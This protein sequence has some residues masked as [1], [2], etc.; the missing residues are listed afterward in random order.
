MHDGCQWK[1]LYSPDG[2]KTPPKICLLIYFLKM[3]LI[4]LTLPR[5]S[6]EGTLSA[7]KKIGSS[8]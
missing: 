6:L 5:V 8:P 4:F 2:K 3:E 7:K 1:L